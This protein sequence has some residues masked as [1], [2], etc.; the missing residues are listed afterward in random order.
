LN[1]KNLSQLMANASGITA[2]AAEREGKVIVTIN[3]STKSAEL[4][5]QIKKMIDGVKAF[6]ELA[7]RAERPTISDLL[8]KAQVA[9][10]GTN[11]IGTFEHDAKTLLATLQKIDAENKAA[12]RK[13]A[14]APE[15]GL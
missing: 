2:C 14:A 11:V 4:A 15:K 9:V 13:A 7:T 12:A 10:D 1:D 5:G 3:I 6:G 8:G